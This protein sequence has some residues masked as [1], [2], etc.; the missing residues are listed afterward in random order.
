MHHLIKGLSSDIFFSCLPSQGADQFH[1]LLSGQHNWYATSHARPTYCN[2]CREALSG[3]YDFVTS[4]ILL[5]TSV[6]GNMTFG[7]TQH[8]G[9]ILYQNL[10]YINYIIQALFSVSFT[11]VLELFKFCECFHSKYPNYCPF[12]PCFWL[13]YFD[14]HGLLPAVYQYVYISDTLFPQGTNHKGG[15]YGR[16]VSWLPYRNTPP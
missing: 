6:Y 7:V 11:C 10:L 1:S 16:K 8:Y 14:D 3:M 12:Q 4:Y 5:E 15:G 9:K 2:V 13:F